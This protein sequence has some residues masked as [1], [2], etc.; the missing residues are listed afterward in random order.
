MNDQITDSPEELEEPETS[1]VSVD[2]QAPEGDSS[3]SLA[4][5]GAD[6]VSGLT[7]KQIREYVRNEF[8]SLKDTRIAKLESAQ[9]ETS[10]R[11]DQYEKYRES[12]LTPA[13]AKRELAVD[14]LLA[15]RKPQ[16]VQQPVNS[17]LT[18]VEAQALASSLTSGLLPE[19]QQ[20]VL[21]QVGQN[22]F[23]NQ[24]ALNKFVV[25]QSAAVA[26]KPVATPASSSS[27]SA[28]STASPAGSE[29][30]TT[31]YSKDMIAARGKPGEIRAIKDQARKDGVDVDN[32]G[33]TI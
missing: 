17:G 14:E 22:A 29:E 6:Q 4:N 23:P 12:G 31:K 21:T 26:S 18:A 16:P 19:A 11:L 13:Q 28:Q 7:E 3:D 1:Q 9:E 27:P 15:N 32:I 10:T 24:E 33:F 2:S 8:Q 25:K 20:A 30:L 5:E